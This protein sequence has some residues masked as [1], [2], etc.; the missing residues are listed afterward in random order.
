MLTLC[1]ESFEPVWTDFASGVTWTPEWR[2]DVNAMGEIPVLEV[3]GRKLTQTGPILLQLS[4]R[5]GRYGGRDEDERSEVLRWLFW[6]NQKLSGFMASYRFLRTFSRSA[7]PAVLAWQRRRVD[8]FLSIAEAHL[9]DRPFMV[10][11]APTVADLS[12]C[13]YLS[14]PADETG[15]DL[16]ASHPNI[17]AW[18]GRIAALPG[19]RS[20]YDL[21][22]GPRLPRYDAG[23]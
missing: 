2:R 17:A 16:P 15:Y 12:M 22:P 4:Q 1:G 14:F 8:D 21:L 20:P 23:A 18:L 19:W 5:F 13:A 7:D 11:E 3:E 10:G 6:D 9:A